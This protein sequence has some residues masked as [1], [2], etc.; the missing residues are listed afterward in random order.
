[1]RR[2]AVEGFVVEDDPRHIPGAEE[3]IL[4]SRARN[5]NGGRPSVASRARY[6]CQQRTC[7]S[8]QAQRD[9]QAPCRAPHDSFANSRLALFYFAITHR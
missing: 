3:E 2:R 5:R 6:G 8:H 1:M 4:N 9:D 7:D